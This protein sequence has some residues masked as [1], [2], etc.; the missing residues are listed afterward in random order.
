MTSLRSRIVPRALDGDSVTRCDWRLV[1]EVFVADTGVEALRHSVG[2]MMGRMMTEYFRP[3]LGAP[4][5]SGP[6][7]I[8]ADQRGARSAT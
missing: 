5:G 3:L 6:D 1:R 8:D 2:G 7:G 4:L